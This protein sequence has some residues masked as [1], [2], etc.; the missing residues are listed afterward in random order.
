MTELRPV[1]LSDA[2]CAHSYGDVILAGQPTADDLRM[3]SEGG[4]REVV[5]LRMTD[6]DRGFAEQARV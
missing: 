3:L 1:E 2:V 6:E 5:D 4:M